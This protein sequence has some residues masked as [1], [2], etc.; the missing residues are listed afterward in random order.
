VQPAR[1][2][3]TAAPARLPTAEPRTTTDCGATKSL[4]DDTTFYQ[5]YLVL[6]EPLPEWRVTT[7]VTT[8]PDNTLI[9]KVTIQNV[10]LG[11]GAPGV[12]SVAP[13]TTALQSAQVSCNTSSTA[14][15]VSAP[16]VTTPLQVGKSVTVT[17]SG[18]P[19]PAKSSPPIEREGTVL[20]DSKCQTVEINEAVNG[21]GLNGPDL[22]PSLVYAKYKI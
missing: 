4:T 20:V 7:I 9:F 6:A 12:V 3:L 13:D 8:K 2:F 1:F 5:D 16:A 14:G 22:R 15:F 17:I 11:P 18:V 19:A 21:R 10:G